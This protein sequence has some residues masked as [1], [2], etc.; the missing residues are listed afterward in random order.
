MVAVLKPK[1]SETASAV[2]TTSDLAVGEICMNVADQKVYTRK[3]DNSIVIVASHG[4]TD[5]DGSVTTAKL[6]DGAVT[7]IKLAADAVDGTKLADNACNSEHY[8]DDSV[9]DIHIS[10][11]AASKLTGTI[12]P[13]DNTVTGAKIALGSDAAGD[14]MY[15]NGTNY[16]R[17]AKGTNGEVLT[18]AGG[19]PSWAADSTNVGATS[20]G[21]DVTGTVANIQIAAN[22]VD[23][24]HIA[25]GSDAAGDVMYYNGTNYVRLA[26]GTATQVLTMNSGATAPEWAADSTNVTGTSVG[27][28]LSGT[29]GNAQI[30]SNK[31][32]I[33]ELNVS[34]GTAGQILKTNGSGTL[35]FTDSGATLQQATAKA[36]TMAIAL[37]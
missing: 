28:D 19:V 20:V 13:S 8:T 23:G 33:T 14:V 1:K 35:S 4:L 30:A 27:G 31:V 25:L 2:P 37:G 18:L 9:D 6:A 3:S 22:A 26:K 10:G 29:V 16:I 11:M 21:G 15:Y 34:D 17:L 5:L 36:V 12:T 32:G 7:T 24:T